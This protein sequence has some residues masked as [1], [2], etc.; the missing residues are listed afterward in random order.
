MTSGR[1]QPTC[2][3]GG[4]L[5]GV[6]GLGA[7]LG[8][9]FGVVTAELG[10]TVAVVVAGARCRTTGGGVT[11]RGTAATA[12]GAG[13]AVVVVVTVVVGAWGGVDAQQGACVTCCCGN[14]FAEMMPM[15]GP[16]TNAIKIVMIKMRALH[17]S[18]VRLDRCGATGV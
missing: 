17:G 2:S 5:G 12:T 4:L 8:G 6:E 7:E 14:I 10:G 11:V 16:T 18:Q 13:A 3:S 9:T 15:A 1:Y